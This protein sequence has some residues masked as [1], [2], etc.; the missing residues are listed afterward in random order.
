MVTIPFEGGAALVVGGSGGLGAAICV[1]LAR[2][3]AHVALTYRTNEASARDVAAEVES[4]GRRAQFAQVDVRDETAVTAAVSHFA[5][6]FGGLHTI[7]FAA[8]PPVTQRFASQIDGPQWRQAL[9]VEANGF[10]Y[11]ASA[12]LPH[13]RES[14]GNL[15]A[16]TSAALRRHVAKD[17]LS[18]A[19]KAAVEATIRAIA[20]EEGRFGV[21]A[22]TVAVGA[23]DGG[24]YHRLR[25]SED[26]DDSWEHAALRNIP[27]QRLGRTDELANVVA[28]LASPKASYITGQRLVVDGG[29]SV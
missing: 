23:F 22:N 6:Q 19:P 8:G 12:G 13:L 2:G 28:F 18:T 27:L 24:M 9:D 17:L 1:A 29:F 15:I 5:K 20:R 3:G 11:V 25:D 26:L 14:R 16:L 21:R 4:F 10:F 7:V